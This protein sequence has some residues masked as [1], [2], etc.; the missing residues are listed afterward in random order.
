MIKD[1]TPLLTLTDLVL[2]SHNE[3]FMQDPHFSGTSV[4]KAE[5]TSK[6]HNECINS[7]H[8]I[9]DILST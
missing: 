6:E 9:S 5:V 7:I 8:A 2:F 1:Q 3:Q 4:D